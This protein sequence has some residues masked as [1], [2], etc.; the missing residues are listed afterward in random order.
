MSQ[1]KEFK[2]D[3]SVISIQ[4]ALFF[5]DLLR[6]PEIILQKVANHFKSM[7]LTPF[8]IQNQLYPVPSST[9]VT[10]N[11]NMFGANSER[12]DFIQTFTSK[13]DS[14]LENN[15]TRDAQNILEYVCSEQPISRIGLV[16]IL[17]EEAK[18]PIKKMKKMYFNDK[19]TEDLVELSI[20]KNKQTIFY[21]IKVNNIYSDEVVKDIAIFG[22]KKSGIITR[23]DIN[24]FFIEEGID[25]EILNK[26]YKENISKI[27]W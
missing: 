4:M 5:K 3:K 13:M 25:K 14:N 7:N 19:I 1:Q 23:H 6:N 10:P 8:L 22:E 26:F 20:R 21:D 12:F 17:F 11:P 24:T 18:E 15:F 2:M 9:I 16:S 27:F